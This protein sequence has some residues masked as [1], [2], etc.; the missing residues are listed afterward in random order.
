VHEWLEAHD[1]WLLGSGAQRQKRSDERTESLRHGNNGLDAQRQGG[2]RF[3]QDDASVLR[4]GDAAARSGVEFMATGPPDVAHAMHS[5]G[6]PAQ[7]QTVDG[8]AATATCDGRA[9]RDALRSAVRT[10]A[11]VAAAK[12]LICS[13]AGARR[14]LWCLH[15]G[16]VSTISR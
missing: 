10:A 11:A 13:K 8:V 5:V 7:L 9:W 16:G 12:H 4:C 2:D 15:P 14:L 1:S 3:V 6:A